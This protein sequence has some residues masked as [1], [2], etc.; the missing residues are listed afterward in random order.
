VIEKGANPGSSETASD[1][2]TRH[3]SRSIYL[4]TVLEHPDPIVPVALPTTDNN[5][6]AKLDELAQA[7]ETEIA[8]RQAAEEVLRETEQWFEQLTKNIGRFCWVTDLGKNRL[9]YIS[10]G[11]EKVWSYARERSYFSPHEWLASLKV[12]DLNEKLSHSPAEPAKHTKER[13]YQVVDS[14]GAMRWIR[15]RTFPIYDEG[16]K[17]VRLFGIA[18]DVTESKRI[19]ETLLRNEWKTRALLSVIQD[20]VVRVRKDGTIL[21]WHRPSAHNGTPVEI[22]GKPLSALL[23]AELTHE[24]TQSIEHVLRTNEPRV[25]VGQLPL[26]G[27]LKRFQAHLAMSGTDEVLVVV[28]ELVAEAD[29]QSC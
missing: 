8:R 7:L 2:Q 4:T 20:H 1:P 25:V 29:P 22:V 23:P 15:D 10:P 16:G 13:E 6:A 18:E 28:R 5:T 11:Y 27:V 9:V 12:A 24:A 14:D 21:E 17:V 19:E 3:S 26:S